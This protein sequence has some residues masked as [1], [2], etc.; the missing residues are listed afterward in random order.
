MYHV[1]KSFNKRPALIDINLHVFKGDFV[2]V[3]GQSGAGKSTLLKLI[4]CAEETDSGQVLITGRNIGRLKKNLIPFIRQTLGIVFQDFKL[5][6]YKTAYENIAL[7]LE[8]QG[9]SRVRIDKKIVEV[10][11][12]L[13]IIH[14]MK[15][16][17]DNLSGGE[18]QRVAIARAIVNNPS[19]LIADEPTGNLDEELTVEIMNIFREINNKGTT[20][21]VA[22]HD[23][24]LLSLYSKKVI[25]LSEGKIINCLG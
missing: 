23:K 1:Y 16:Y 11:K 4:Y 21:I 17:P 20:V 14:K 8:A 19:I 15:D 13:G 18:Q 24:K 25:T 3:T 2:F 6:P 9:I 10:C 7:V 12:K 5:I 22:T